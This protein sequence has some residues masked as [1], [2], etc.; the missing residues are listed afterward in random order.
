MSDWQPKVGD[1]V[2]YP[3]GQGVLITD[4]PDINDVVIVK[5]EQGEYRRVSVFNIKP[6]PTEEEKL[7]DEFVKDYRYIAYPTNCSFEEKSKFIARAMLNKG[8]RKVEPID[9]D[10]LLNLCDSNLPSYVCDYLIE[11]NHI[12]VKGE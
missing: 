11:N 9:Y 1:V 3:S 6:L 12:V 8:Y 2:K 10:D 7:I 5:D 4:E